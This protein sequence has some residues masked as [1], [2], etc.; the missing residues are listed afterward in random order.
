MLFYQS[1]CLLSFNLRSLYIIQ[2]QADNCLITET[3]DLIL[4]VI[5]KPN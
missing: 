1:Y 5:I 2:L 3:S 4:K